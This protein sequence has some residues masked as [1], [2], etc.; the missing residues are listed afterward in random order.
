MSEEKGFLARITGALSSTGGAI[1][2]VVGAVRDIQKM[3][4]DYE[5]KEKTYDLLDKLGDVQQQQISLQELLMAAKNRI[6]E[7]EQEANNRDQWKREK[8][9]YELFHPM[10]TTVVY[11]LK[12]SSDSNQQTHYLCTNCYNSS[13][14]SILQYKKSDFGV[15][16]LICHKCHSQYQF[17]LELTIDKRR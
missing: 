15:S 7:L 14:K 9:N 3:H 16:Y 5:V 2:S 8:L 13:M 17:P 12:V 10:K 4:I 11:R 6:I 1:S